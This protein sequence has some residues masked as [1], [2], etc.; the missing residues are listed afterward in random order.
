MIHAEFLSEF[1]RINTVY[2]E[3]LYP[4][5]RVTRIWEAVKF[6]NHR[7]WESVVGNIVGEMMKPPMLSDFRQAVAG[8]HRQ[9]EGHKPIAAM[10]FERT[11]CAC[12]WCGHSGWIFAVKR[13]ELVAGP[14]AFR[15]ADCRAHEILEHSTCI[16]LWSDRFSQSY[17]PKLFCGPLCDP[18][19]MP[20]YATPPVY[21]E[22]EPDP[23]PPSGSDRVAAVIASVTAALAAPILELP[24]EATQQNWDF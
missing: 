19:D 12:R 21:A 1:C 3:K 14:T 5:E 24:Q 9:R 15:C 23:A 7:E 16:P 17:W 10:A 8:Y 2:G 11:T 18:W 13:D 6:L 4:P 22:P 20:T